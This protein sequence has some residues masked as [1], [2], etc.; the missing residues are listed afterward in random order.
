[1]LENQLPRIIGFAGFGQSGKDEAYLRGLKARGYKRLGFADELKTEL[2]AAFGVTTAQINEEKHIWRPM[3]VALG[4]L[5]R[6]QDPRYWIDKV[7]NQ[8][9]VKYKYCITD[10]R[11]CNECAEVYKRAGNVYIIERPNTYPA[12][13]TESES[14]EAIKRWFQPPKIMNDSTREVLGDRVWEFVSSRLKKG[15]K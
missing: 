14:I 4:E 15:V 2:S 6:A 7:F 13:E 1:M 12:N 11:Y 5:R 8:I 3:M 9:D 10:V